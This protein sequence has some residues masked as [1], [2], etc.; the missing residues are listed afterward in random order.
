VAEQLN[1]L[2]LLKHKGFD[3]GSRAASFSSDQQLSVGMLCS[4]FP[5]R[6]DRDINALLPSESRGDEYNLCLR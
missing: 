3:F 2:G 4:E 5:E 6:E 1:A